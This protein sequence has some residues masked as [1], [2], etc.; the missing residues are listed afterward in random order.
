L[1][2]LLVFKKDLGTQHFHCENSVLSPALYLFI[3]PCHQST[4]LPM[5]HQAAT[6]VV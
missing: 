5:K 4:E 1:L 3:F 6:M 2:L